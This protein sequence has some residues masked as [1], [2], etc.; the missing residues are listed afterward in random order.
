MA[1]RHHKGRVFKPVVSERKTKL[2]PIIWCTGEAYCIAVSRVPLSVKMTNK[3]V[4]KATKV[5]D[6]SQWQKWN[7]VFRDGYHID[8]S[9]YKD[10][11]IV[12]CTKCGQP[13]DFRL[14]PSYYSPTLTAIQEHENQISRIEELSDTQTQED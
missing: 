8:M 7:S 12:L 11:D 14:F 5:V 6:K 2:W 1:Q 13:V 4:M 3:G 9:N 10:G